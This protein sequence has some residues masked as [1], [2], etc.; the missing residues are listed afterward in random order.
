MAAGHDGCQ[1]VC[2]HQGPGDA[3]GQGSGCGQTRQTPFEPFQEEMPRLHTWGCCGVPAG[4]WGCAR[5]L[6]AFGAEDAHVVPGMTVTMA[7]HGLS[8]LPDARLLGV[9]RGDGPD[10][11]NAGSGPVTG[12]PEAR[13]RA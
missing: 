4:L 8:P 3:K 6:G 12:T 9:R 13:S 10:A 11:C 5:D 1:Q 7:S 2:G